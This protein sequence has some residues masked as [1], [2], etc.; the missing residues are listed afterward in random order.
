MPYYAATP[1]RLWCVLNQ[2]WAHTDNNMKDTLYTPFTPTRPTPENDKDRTKSTT[3]WDRLK[4][5][6][7]D[8]DGC[9]ADTTSA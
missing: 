4:A 8:I 6:A 3:P 9:F 1:P 7:S 2:E 5:S